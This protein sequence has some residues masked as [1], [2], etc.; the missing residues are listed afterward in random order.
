MKKL[1][2][3]IL[4]VI[5]LAVSLCGVSFAEG[6]NIL[7]NPGFED[8][9]KPYSWDQ[10]IWEASDGQK[11]IKVVNNV[12]HSGKQ[13]AVIINSKEGDSRLKQTVDVQSDS[14]YKISGWIKT[15]N[16]GDTNK[17]ANFSVHM[18]Q[19]TS[20]D[21]KGTTD[22]KYVEM[23]GRTGKSQTSL[24]VTAGLGGYGSLNTG[25]AYFDD[26]SVEKVNSVPADSVEFAFYSNDASS[27]GS[28]DSDKSWLIYL[29]LALLAAIGVV[30]FFILRKPKKS[31]ANSQESTDYSTSLKKGAAQ[32]ESNPAKNQPPPFKIDKKDLIVMGVMTLVYLVIALWNLGEMT[33]PETFWKPISS[34]QSFVVSFDKEYE[35][36]RIGYHDNIG[37]GKYTL[38]GMDPSGKYVN[39]G[40]M[41]QDV[42]NVFR[43]QHISDINFRTKK[44][45]VIVESSG[46]A[47]N[48][49][50]FYAKGSKE[51]IKGFKLEEINTNPKRDQGKVENLFDEQ[52]TARYYNNYMNSTYFDEIYHPRT[53]Y[54]H[55]NRME[56]YET[57]HPPLG[58]V[59]MTL[60]ILL[61]GMNPFGFRIMGTIFGA[62]M[63]PAMYLLG[64]KVFHK[65]IFAFASAFLM[66]FEFMHF[67]QTRIGT[68]DSYPG[69]FIILTY[70]FM[71]DAF[72]KKSYK[73]GFKNSLKPLL[74]AGIFWGLAAAS[75]WTALWTGFGLATL[76]FVA[77]GLELW[78][79]KKALSKKIKGKFPSWTR[80]FI[81]NKLVLTPLACVVF[82]VVIPGIIYVSSYLPIITLPGPS[83]NLEE[84]VR[85]QKNMYDYHANLDATHP[86]QSNP[87]EWSVGYKPLLEYRDT[88]QP[89]GKVSLMYT[90]GH[91]IIFWFGLASIFAIIGI[92]I[93][94][95]DKRVFFILIAY[96]FQYIPW[97]IT[98]RGGCMFIY[99]YFTAIPFL[100]MALVY[101]LKFVHDDL[102][103]IIGKAYMSKQA[104]E[105]AR[106]VTKCICYI[107]LAIVA[108]FFIWF[109][110]ALSG[111]VMSDD[112]HN[113]LKWFNVL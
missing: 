65:R 44:V 18:L 86:Y 104:E 70:F 16:V 49:M 68:I 4:S 60:G 48:E 14:L 8:A 109:Y 40:T 35:L 66:M 78:D 58:K 76:F 74:L 27:G 80:D 41:S 105:K 59:I 32:T 53:A 79:Y 61:F 71:Y 99:H 19:I 36:S 25:T 100:I 101:L 84:V 54:E 26:I 81:K 106:L 103:K 21:V 43:W 42:Y 50:V 29:G 69:L 110:P 22:W 13:C 9:D 39:I 92:G 28:S 23:Y 89:A 87:W 45:K 6:S 98:N 55:I 72:I 10:D 112:Y 12:F 34:G 94:K 46:A 96:G 3:P 64:K 38:Q 2:L 88:N 24:I 95:R 15:E 91:P 90:M 67:A 93:W 83:H 73:T 85:Y 62:L 52:D 113:T 37:D 11:E 111:K 17:G 108:I 20:A 47:L 75:K 5:I 33:A 31:A 56:P 97:F 82:F 63:I 1:L 77:M 102:P 7:K 107:F 30:I 51:P 57:T